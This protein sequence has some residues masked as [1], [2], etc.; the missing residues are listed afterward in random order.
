MP[1]PGNPQALQGQGPLVCLSL[2]TTGNGQVDFGEPVSTIMFEIV[3]SA[4]VSAGA[5]TIEISED[6]VNWFAP[7][8]STV[9]SYSA[10]V[11]ANPYTL[12]A[13]TNALF[14]VGNANIAVR[15]ARARISTTVVGGTVSA[16][17]SGY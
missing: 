17:A 2:A 8:T 3:V 10:V 11:A 6:G 12:V 15:Y 1:V 9:T 7:P 5:I 4:G 16:I 14:D 13:S